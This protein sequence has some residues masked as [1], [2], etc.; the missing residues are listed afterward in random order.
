MSGVLFFLDHD[1][2]EAGHLVRKYV[3]PVAVQHGFSEPPG[4]KR[5]I[6]A[7][8]RPWFGGLAEPNKIQA[9]RS[10]VQ[11]LLTKSSDFT[12]NVVSKTLKKHRLTFLQGSFF[13]TGIKLSEYRTVFHSYQTDKQVGEGG[14][15]TVWKVRR[16]D[17]K[18]F[19]MKVLSK[20][21]LQSSRRKR[22][23][24]ELW[25]CAQ[26]NHRN[27]VKVLDWGLSAI[28]AERNP[29]RAAVHSDHS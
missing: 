26:S 10:I 4:D 6:S 1:Y 28:N 15:A 25:F 24:N 16:D 17:N 11:H 9:L 20:V 21:D 19:A 8:I 22:F 14:N 29:S 27:I 2:P 13:D 12:K 5:Q 18:P 23:S 3:L 7:A